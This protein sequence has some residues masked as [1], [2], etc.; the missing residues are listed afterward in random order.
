M[1][2]IP[3]TSTST[4]ERLKLERAWNEDMIGDNLA[5]RGLNS[6]HRI[7]VQKGTK[8][9]LWTISK[10]QPLTIANYFVDDVHA[11]SDEGISVILR[12]EDYT[13]FRA[14]YFPTQLP[15]L[16]VFVWVPAF[17]SVRYAPTDYK[18]GGLGARNLRVSLCIKARAVASTE[19]RAG[20]IFLST[21]GEFQA[22][23]TPD[24]LLLKA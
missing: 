23:W 1:S 9:V 10:R 12:R 5:W 18:E 4:G 2:G 6:T 11:S 14:T 3:I 13:R 20:D 21:L 7:N 17:S 22:L 19:G 15:S 24:K 8:L 16:P